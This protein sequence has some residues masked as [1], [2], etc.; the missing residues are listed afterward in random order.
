MIAVLVLLAIG[1][2]DVI[3]GLVELVEDARS[4]RSRAHRPGPMWSTIGL[5]I[6]AVAIAGTALFGWLG[7]GVPVAM[8]ALAALLAWIWLFAAWLFTRANRS[9]P[10]LAYAIVLPVVVAILLLV[11]RSI[12]MDGP[13]LVWFA[14]VSAQSMLDVSAASV[15]GAIAVGLFLTRS[16]NLVCKAALRRTLSHD[17]RP[18][19]EQPVRWR[20][21]I[22]GR[23][24]A[25]VSADF[26]AAGAPAQAVERARLRG[27]RV[28]GPLE[29]LMITALALLGLEAIVVGVIAAKGIVRFP[30]I[31]ADGRNGS[32]AEEFLVGSLVSWSSAGLAALML[33]SL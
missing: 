31:Y 28:I 13:V 10:L 24:V 32:K 14:G 17:E 25:E 23:R 1:V 2:G 26:A 12:P 19:V 20:L 7:L 29:R 15:L 30:E 11:S 16:M 5:A 9:V 33:V 21:R 22:G 6:A 27:G 4:D 3:T 8:A 18:E